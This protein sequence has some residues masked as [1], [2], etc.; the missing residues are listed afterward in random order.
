LSQGSLS[1]CVKFSWGKLGLIDGRVELDLDIVE[2]A[3]QRGIDRG[4]TG[5]HG[6][7]AEGGYRGG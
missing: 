4:V 6:S 5:K 2:N 1:E 7:D 3:A